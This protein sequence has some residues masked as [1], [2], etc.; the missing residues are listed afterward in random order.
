MVCNLSSI[1][2]GRAVPANVL[3]R[4]ISIQ[5]RMLD[6]VIDINTLPV[7]QAQIT[8]QRYRAIGGGTFGLHHLLALEG[9]QWESE[10]A[11][12]F[13]D[14][15]YEKINYLTI[16][17]SSELAKEK[18][19][20]PLFEGSDWQTGEYFKLREYD[21]PKW[22]EL[23][24]EVSEHGVRNGYLLAVAPNATTSVIAGSTASTDPIF[25]P[26]YHE[27]KG[28]FKLPIVAPDLNHKT[29]N[30]YR[31]SAY[32]VDQFWSIKQN[33]ARQRHVDQAIS[34]N[35]YVPNTIRAS[36]LLQLHI[37]AWKANLKTSYYVR[38]SADNIQNCEWCE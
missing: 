2:L 28:D 16:K 22:K 37:E 1:N 24:G 35:Y 5:I 15:L 10:E 14:A 17:A 20:Y 8:N 9:I 30:V 4:L 36:I 29:Y 32:V 18:G 34:F 26:F 38:S 23:Q 21:S 19:H 11:V 7:A 3:E 6:N 31:R 27:E 12:E 13:N 25:L 33:A